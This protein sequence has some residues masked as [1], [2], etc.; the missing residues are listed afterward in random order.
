MRLDS[1]QVLSVNEDFFLETLFLQEASSFSPLSHYQEV[2]LA[3]QIERGREAQHYLG[4]GREKK[5]EWTQR[6]RAAQ[7][8]LVEANLKL[9]VS[10]ARN[11]MGQGLDFLDIVQEGAL[12]LMEAIER[13]DWREGTRFTS[14][15]SFWVWQHIQRAIADQ[16]HTIRIPVQMSERTH[17]LQKIAQQLEKKRGGKPTAEEI[18]QKMN[19][20]AEEVWFLSQLPY[21][22]LSWEEA[23]DRESNGEMMGLTQ[24][25][26]TSDSSSAAYQ[27]MLAEEM[28]KVLATLDPR[29]ERILRLRYGLQDGKEYTLEQVGERF[30]LTR[31]R[32]RQIEQQALKKLRHP[33]RS[34]SL[35]GYLGR[36]YEGGEAWEKLFIALPPWD[37]VS[38]G[39]RDAD[40]ELPDPLAGIIDRFLDN[41]QG[42]EGHWTRGQRIFWAL[43]KLGGSAR[44]EAIARQVNEDTPPEEQIS[45]QELRRFL[46]SYPFTFVPVGEGT[47]TFHKDVAKVADQREEGLSGAE[48][49]RIKEVEAKPTAYHYNAYQEVDKIRELGIELFNP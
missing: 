41:W 36:G 29:E 24:V 14:Y 4:E 2:D 33:R 44:C 19:I 47:F 46:E 5:D 6:G 15:A 48:M 49:R 9:V 23:M 45:K 17:E 32:I 3:K 26:S 12:G 42:E 40:C 39:F 43:E 7:Q 10:T 22:M 28:G 16:G 8:R 13:F 20:K 34:R 37:Q 11:Y 25:E 31:E 30:G 35:H 38:L 18:A 27:M 1:H 21:R